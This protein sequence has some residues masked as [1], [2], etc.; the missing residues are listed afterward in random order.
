MSLG[1]CSQRLREMRSAEEWAH[2][3]LD[4]NAALVLGWR[5]GRRLTA[6]RL[7]LA[8]DMHTILQQRAEEALGSIAHRVSREYTPDAHLE[9]DEAFLLTTRDLPA[10]PPRRRTRRAGPDP[11]LN[12]QDEASELIRCLQRPG[13]LDLI[14]PDE[15][16]GRTFLFYAVVFS[17]PDIS[18]AFVKRHNA[19]VALKEG[20][21]F[22]LLGN[23]VNRVEEPVLVFESDFD[24]IIEGEEIAALSANALPRLFADLE[25]AAAAVPTHVK[26]LTATTRMAFS[27]SSLSA[28]ETACTRRRLLALRLHRLIQAP[29][30]QELSIPMVEGYLRELGEDTSRYITDDEVSV[31]EGDVAS[32]LD[33]LHQ[34]HY[35][36]GYD[37]RIHRADRNSIVS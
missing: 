15:A 29:Y 7:G 26:T 2:R 4:G 34:L 23:E 24:L 31:C 13:D 18:I 25:V 30:L 6:G 16:R 12:D 37:G 3:P 10:A 33:I 32:L 36:G 20:R 14:A 27:Q 8:R 35:R 17:T 28:I 1:Y 9:S 19:G 11:G 21:I 22:G 5:T